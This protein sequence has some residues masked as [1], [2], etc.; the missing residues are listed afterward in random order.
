MV[1]LVEQGGTHVPLGSSPCESRQWGGP[2]QSLSDSIQSLVGLRSHLTSRWAESVCNLIKEHSSES[3]AT[4][5]HY[6]ASDSCE[7]GQDEMGATISKLQGELAALRAQVINLNLEKRQ[8]LHE[9]L[10]LKGN[11]RVYCRIRPFLK[12]EECYHQASVVSSDSNKLQL[13]VGQNRTKEYT[14]DKVFHPGT[15]QDEVFEEVEPVIKAA[16]D[17][18]NVCIFAYGQTGTG[19]T[20]TMEG[21]PDCPGVVPRA[22]KTLFS[23][24]SDSNQKIGFYF[25]MLEVY[26]GNLR[27]LL[28]P[29]VEKSSNSSAQSLSIQMDPMGGIEIENLVA[30]P[31]NDFNQANK[32]YKYGRRFRS[33][34][35]T[36]SNDTSSRSHCLIRISINCIDAP[37]RRRVVNKIWMVD[38]G[39]SERLLKTQ[40]TGKRLE[41]GKAINLSLSA[42]GD[43]IS[44]LQ[45]KH[46]HVPYRNS[47]LTQLLRDSLGEDSKTLMLVHISPNEADLGE[48]ICSLG[49]AT[50]AKQ[51]RLGREESSGARAEKEAA[52][53]DLLQKMRYLEDK[54]QDIKQSIQKAEFVLNESLKR[55]GRLE[56][57]LAEE[58]TETMIEM[59]KSK[60]GNVVCPSLKLPRFMR[61]TECSRQKYGS[62]FFSYMESSTKKERPH[63]AKK[64]HPSS[65]KSATYPSKAKSQSEL[66]T[67]RSSCLV[68]LNWKSSMGYETDYSNG[69]SECEVKRVVFPLN[70][71]AQ[72]NYFEGD[73]AS[74][75]WPS[76]KDKRTN[77]YTSRRKRVLAIPVPGDR[78]NGDPQVKMINKMKGNLPNF[79][80]ET[81]EMFLNNSLD[82]R[83]ADKAYEDLFENKYSEPSSGNVSEENMVQLLHKVGETKRS[84]MQQRTDNNQC[85]T[86]GLVVKFNGLNLTCPPNVVE[87]LSQ[88]EQFH[89]V[90][91]NLEPREKGQIQPTGLSHKMEVGLVKVR[92]LDRK[93]KK[94]DLPQEFKEAENNSKEATCHSPA[95]FDVANLPDIG[96]KERKAYPGFCY[97]F[98]QT[99]RGFWG[100]LLLGLG[101][102]GLGFGDEF[103][104][105]LQF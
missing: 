4:R 77:N 45:E 80:G 47:K 18:Y 81:M 67:S 63:V 104:H 17:G 40:A 27:D 86:D 105:G 88:N 78:R 51:I 7:N 26:M 103:Y 28:N 95:H 20:F 89:E 99:V 5:S 53:A 70:V 42:L 59:E 85:S 60:I 97:V 102:Q 1:H 41:E 3:L 92:L 24:A 8:I 22:I 44:A 61:P 16:L 87:N 30:I 65:V 48:T 31:V 23:L 21:R 100:S 9:L 39:G 101:I 46:P 10:D 71:K 34:A 75:N 57:H 38:L 13:R 37:E 29:Q 83:D 15:S 76:Q 98:G 64:K 68:G 52:M 62:D 84:P 79:H 66:S 43:V 25:S 2:S 50:R 82:V 96:F 94:E 36:N 54:S 73:L 32:L 11:I 55:D 93:E 69:T 72:R 33:T 14:F 56:P 90:A 49:F 12:D 35:S 6:V 19:K 58:E 74:E 91:Q